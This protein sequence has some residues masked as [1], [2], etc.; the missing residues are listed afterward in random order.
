[1]LSGEEALDC[2]GKFVFPGLIDAHVHFRDPGATHKED[3]LTGSRAALSGGVTTVLDMPNNSPPVSTIEALEQKIECAGK[4]ACDYSLFFG[5]TND[6]SLAKKA[7]ERREVCALKIYM[8]SSTGS[9]LVSEEKKIEANMREF[10]KAKPVVVH[11]ESEALIQKN[12]LAFTEDSVL[13]HNKIRDE[14]V[15]LEEAKTAIRLGKKACRRLHV[16]HCSTIGEL[17]E[18]AKA[19]QDAFPVTC[20]VSPHHLLLNEEDLGKLGNLGRMNP[21]LRSKKQQQS[22]LKNFAL[23]DCIAT[24]H[25]P[26]TREE[27][28]QAYS[29]APSGVPG[30]ETMLP[31]LL[32]LASEKKITLE[33]IVEKTSLNPSRIFGL[34]NKGE[35][36]PGFDADLVIVDLEKHGVIEDQKLFTKCGW[37]PFAG[38]NTVG[39]VEKTFLRGQLAFENGKVLA[40]TGFGKLVELIQ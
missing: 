36:K 30:V 7:G 10:N 38:W 31:L 9:L 29:K 3:F 2:S 34:K 11:A 37:S 22:V 1:G 12:A 18:V 15:A 21:P 6:S 4:S 35:L 32:T 33:Q 17:R 8:G 39:A 40:Q 14:Q 28:N 19:K 24:D 16:A 27:K 25:A 26:H 23:I 13:V 20:E 5:A